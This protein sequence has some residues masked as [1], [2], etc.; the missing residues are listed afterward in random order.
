[1]S[2]S[3]TSPFLSR[4][5][6]PLSCFE[7]L[8]VVQGNIVCRAVIVKALFVAASKYVVAFEVD[9]EVEVS[10]KSQFVTVPVMDDTV[11]SR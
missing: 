7:F 5:T 11:R 1:M 8:P 3:S 2:G 6:F 10:D 4:L 9:M